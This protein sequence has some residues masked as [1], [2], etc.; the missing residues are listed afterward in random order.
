MVGA[1]GNVG[2]VTFLTLYALDAVN[3]SSFFLIIA[4]AAVLCF[5]MSHK[6]I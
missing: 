6:V 4:G 1:F 2:G 5:W 3:A